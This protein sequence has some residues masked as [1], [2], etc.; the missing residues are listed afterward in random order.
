MLFKFFAVLMIT[1][2]FQPSQEYLDIFLIKIYRLRNPLFFFRLEDNREMQRKRSK[3]LGLHPEE[4]IA[5]KT[6]AVLLVNCV[7]MNC[8]SQPLSVNIENMK[9]AFF[10]NHVTFSKF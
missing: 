6:P 4:G 2:V 1:T 8:S 3:A 7:A 5:E 10:L 9:R